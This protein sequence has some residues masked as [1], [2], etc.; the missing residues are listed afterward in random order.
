M[1]EYLTIAEEYSAED[2]RLNKYGKEG[3][4]LVGFSISVN[5]FFYYVFKRPLN[6]T[7]T[8]IG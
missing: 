4:E 6:E 7:Q 1:F 8:V 5:N 3:W 2:K